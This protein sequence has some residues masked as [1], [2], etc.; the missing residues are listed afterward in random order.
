MQI[1]GL[2]SLIFIL[3]AVG[4]SIA[5]LRTTMPH[6]SPSA[7][8]GFKGPIGLAKSPQRIYFMNSVS[9]QLILV[10]GQFTLLQGFK[11]LRAMSLCVV[12]AF[13]T[14]ASAVGLVSVLLMMQMS[15]TAMIGIRAWLEQRIAK[16]ESAGISPR[17]ASPA[18]KHARTDTIATFG[19]DNKDALPAIGVATTRGSDFSRKTEDLKGSEDSAIGAPFNFRKEGSI[20]EQNAPNNSNN[21][22]KDNVAP[23]LSP[24]ERDNYQDRGIYNPKTGGYIQATRND[25]YYNTQAAYGERRPSSGVFDAQLSP[26]PRILHAGPKTSNV[27]TKDLW[28]P[29]MPESER[30]HSKARTHKTMSSRYSRPIDGNVPVRDSFMGYGI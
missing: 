13:F 28:P 9:I 11:T 15:A 18:F 10:L 5:R 1:L 14:S 16:K 30:F 27:S 6:P 20:N 17:N 8:V 26:I 2:I 24:E 12:D 7:F 21:N 19:F 29:P 25:D 4:F 23:F 3:P 22:A